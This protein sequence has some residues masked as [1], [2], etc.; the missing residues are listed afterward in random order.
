[1]NSRN[2]S[3]NCAKRETEHA[4]LIAPFDGVVANLFSKPY[5]LGKYF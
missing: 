5:N 1:M 2:P 3:M 4:T